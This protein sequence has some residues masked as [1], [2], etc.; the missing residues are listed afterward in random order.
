M[1]SF[2][3]F[4]NF[5]FQ[6]VSFGHFEFLGVD[7]QYITNSKQIL[8]KKIMTLVAAFFYYRSILGSTTVFSGI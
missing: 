3:G 5:C 2:W 1:F 6:F 8:K 4:R 7:I